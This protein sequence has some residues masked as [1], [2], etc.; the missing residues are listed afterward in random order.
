MLKRNR[1]IGITLILI[2]FGIH[3]LQGQTAEKTISLS[4][5]QCILKALDNNLSVAINVLT[6]QLSEIALTASREKWIPN[7]SFGFGYRNTNQVSYS[8][9]D[10]SDAVE[11]RNDTYSA[12]FSQLLP[13][14]GTITLSV[15]GDK[16]NSNRSFQSINPR[17]GRTLSFNF[18]QP[19]L[20]DFG[21][22]IS[23]REII[24]AQ[25]N[26]DMSELDFKTT[27]EN[28]V[29]SV[30]ENYWNL[31]YSIENL[32]VREQ[33]LQLAEDLLEN[34][35]RAVEVGTM[36][37]LDVL[38]A[39]STVASRRA[40]IIETRAQVKNNEDNLKTLINIAAE[41]DDAD[42]LTIFPTDQPG[43]EKMS[44][45]LDQA[46]ATALDNRANLQSTQLDIKNRE[47]NVS[48]AKNQM[49]PG[50]SLSAR[51]WS[52][53]ITGDQIIYLN[54]N[55]FTGIIVGTVPGSPSDAWKD[56]FGLVY[57][58]LSLT[59]TLDIP[60]DT[61]FTQTTLIQAR[62]N[63]KQAM[64]RLKNQEQQIFQE[65]RN[66][67]RDVE[68]NHQRVQAYK[69]A[70]DLAQR[71]LEGEEERL[72]VGLTTPYFVLQY[73]RDLRNAQIM[74]LRSIMD[75][76]LSLARLQRSTGVILSEKNI[77]IF[78]VLNR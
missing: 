12:D 19:L 5:E 58:N 37:P 42:L 26:F 54:N 65:I 13:T 1:T 30:E 15:D 6:P 78:D 71:Q 41:T 75:Y 11:T 39:E 49:L 55:A 44:V 21:T 63:L 60:L 20:R 7:L 32:K 66:A 45:S 52:P 70:R 73:Q 67:V 64:L 46:L 77:S 34:N 56:A 53:G 59:L 29:Y 50:L 17:Y 72:K 9:L 24:I 43:Y 2:L 4:L 68:T 18:N 16:T 48:W 76:N 51:Y 31:V 33:S 27:L 23:R 62:I 25:N 28:I 61:L 3:G 47:I 74:E 35:R 57:A 8:F 14:G 38:S 36:A 10:A 40:D 69:I 22:K